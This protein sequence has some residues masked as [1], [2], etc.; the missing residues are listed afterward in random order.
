MISCQLYLID[1]SVEVEGGPNDLNIS[2][3]SRSPDLSPMDFFGY[4]IWLHI[5]ILVIYLNIIYSSKN[6]FITGMR[7]RMWKIYIYISW[8]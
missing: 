3:P 7:M 4:Y 5:Y 8:H 1:G 6:K 2:W